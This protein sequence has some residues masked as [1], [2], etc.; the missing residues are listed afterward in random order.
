[1]LLTSVAQKQPSLVGTRLG[2][3]SAESVVALSPSDRSTLVDR[4]RQHVILAMSHRHFGGWQWDWYRD[5]IGMLRD[6]GI[7]PPDHRG[8][9]WEGVHGTDFSWWQSSDVPRGGV[10]YCRSW[11]AYL[12]TKCGDNGDELGWLMLLWSLVEITRNVI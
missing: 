12:N 9:S 2:Y 7:N 6:F 1:M 5:G 8:S 3:V 11:F 10:A 4:C